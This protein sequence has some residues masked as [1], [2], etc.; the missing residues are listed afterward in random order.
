MF[1]DTISNILNRT[2]M[3]MFEH[4]SSIQWRP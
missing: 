1:Q 4:K 3:C 2:F